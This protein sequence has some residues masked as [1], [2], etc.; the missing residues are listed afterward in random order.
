MGS[1]RGREILIAW[2]LSNSK[3]RLEGRN[4]LLEELSTRRLRVTYSICRFGQISAVGGAIT[5]VRSPR[6]ATSYGSI[7]SKQL[8]VSTSATEMDRDFELGFIGAVLSC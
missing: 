5:R 1:N 8:C 6:L 7:A 4:F 2:A 3:A